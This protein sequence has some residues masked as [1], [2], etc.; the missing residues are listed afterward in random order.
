MS[1]AAKA[2][3]VIF[4]AAAVGVIAAGTYVANMYK[5]V[6]ECNAADNSRV[7]ADVVEW[8]LPGGHMGQ[9]TVGSYSMRL[10]DDRGWIAH[11]ENSADFAAMKARAD[12]F[13]T[14]GRLPVNM[15]NPQP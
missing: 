11:S 7:A 12:E 1:P 6:Y 14:T 2:L 13:C 8:T 4:G 10:L 3:T 9:R 15:Q 5:T